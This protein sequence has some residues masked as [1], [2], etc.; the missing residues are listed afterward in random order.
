MFVSVYFVI[1]GSFVVH[2]RVNF[3]SLVCSYNMYF[4]CLFIHSSS[5]RIFKIKCVQ[6]DFE[7]VLDDLIW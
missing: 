4:V 7:S 5:N 1:L 3:C 2:F 6:E